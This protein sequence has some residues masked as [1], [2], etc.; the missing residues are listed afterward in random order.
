MCNLN[1]CFVGRSCHMPNGFVHHAFSIIKHGQIVANGI[2]VTYP[3]GV[4]ELRIYDYQPK[5]RRDIFDYFSNVNIRDIT[6]SRPC[7]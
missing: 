3:D 4:I 2:E 1:R 6:F 5:L 7:E